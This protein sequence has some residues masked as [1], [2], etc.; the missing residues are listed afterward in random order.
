MEEKI[1][2]IVDYNIQYFKQH[3]KTSDLL[4][5]IDAKNEARAVSIEDSKFMADPDSQ[6]LLQ[7][8]VKKTITDLENKH[9]TKI[10]LVLRVF[11]QMI[12]MNK[13]SELDLDNSTYGLDHI[14]KLVIS[15]EDQDR[16]RLDMID[17]IYSSD[18]CSVV[19]SE[20]LV[21][22]EDY[23]KFDPSKEIKGSLVNLI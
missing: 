4:Y 19:L 21:H 7:K 12:D 18:K 22:T 14:E 10:V 16:I 23:F 1:K 6:V 5:L 15:T 9:G 2:T 3:H 20:N 11:E 13:L 17:V 8:I